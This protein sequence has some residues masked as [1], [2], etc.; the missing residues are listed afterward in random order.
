MRNECMGSVAALVAL[1]WIVGLPSNAWHAPQERTRVERQAPT[2]RTIAPFGRGPV[3]FE[4]N[5]GRTDPLVRYLQR[6]PRHLT[7]LTDSGF[8]TRAHESTTCDERGTVPS[9]ACGVTFVGAA[10]GPQWYA[11]GLLPGRTH[12]FV[13]PDA[14]R[15]VRNV[16]GYASV[17]AR[18]VWSGIDVEYHGRDGQLEYDFV[19]APGAD[20]THIAIDVHGADEL[21][22]SRDGD[23]VAQ[24]GDIQFVHGRPTVWQDH[25]DG[26]RPVP[27]RWSLAGENRARIQVAQF[28]ASLP[29]VIDPT[30]DVRFG[31][32]G[33]AEST[34]V[35]ADSSG[36]VA[37]VGHATGTGFPGIAPS[38]GDVSGT[39]DAF[40]VTFDV[41]GDLDDAFL[42]GSLGTDGFADVFFAPDGRAAAA[43]FTS[44]QATFPR[45]GVPDRGGL[46]S[47]D[48][49]VVLVDSSEGDPEFEAAVV[50]GA[51]QDAAT[52]MAIFADGLSG[53]GDYTLFVGIATRSNDLP[54]TPGVAHPDALGGGD[55]ALLG[56]DP[57][58]D[59]IA[60]GYVGGASDDIVGG[61]CRLDCLPDGRVGC[62]YPTF[63]SGLGSPGTIHEVKPGLVDSVIE[64]YSADLSTRI[65]GTYLK[66]VVVS[67]YAIA[68]DGT[69]V[70]SGTADTSSD[71]PQVTQNAPFLVPVDEPDGFLVVVE[72]DLSAEAVASWLPSQGFDQPV[73]AAVIPGAGADPDRFAVIGNCSAGFTPKGGGEGFHGGT[74][75]CYV[76]TMPRT[77]GSLSSAT[78]VGGSTR[79][80]CGATSGGTLGVGVGRP[81]VVLAD[82]T[83][84]AVC[85]TDATPADFP[86]IGDTRF[87]IPDSA[88][89][90][91][92]DDPVGG[93]AD[94][95][96]SVVAAQLRDAAKAG[97]DRASCRVSYV[98]SDPGREGTTAPGGDGSAGIVWT[99]PTRDGADLVVADAVID[100]A[101][102][103]WKARRKGRILAW[104]GRLENGEKARLTIDQGAREMT[105]NVT[106]IDFQA[107]PETSRATF[108]VELTAE[109]PAA[110][111][112]GT[113]Q[114]PTVEQKPGK[115]KATP[116]E[117]FP[118]GLSA[119]L[120]VTPEVLGPDDPYTA[121]VTLR[122][123]DP[124]PVQVTVRVQHP[125][126]TV[127]PEEVATVIE[128][129]V[130]VPGRAAGSAL[131]GLEELTAEFLPP[132]SPKN[133]RVELFVDGAGSQTVFI[134]VKP[135]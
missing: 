49:I 120:S 70:V 18:E 4:P 133:Q 128:A 113:A 131:A 6:A 79:D 74:S 109:S 87:G 36:R 76:V 71:D 48:S 58:L 29:L 96:C 121:R 126:L 47:V 14:S 88:V 42:F 46:G 95:E 102:P 57:S 20:P 27:G 19:V 28:D 108:Q 69:H 124:D 83:M 80:Q 82:G 12:H 51:L 63:S 31:A 40:L 122:N 134:K 22:I 127:F 24:A 64:I 125:V 8:T 110:P 132:N 104:S 39:Q 119:V 115:F 129:I 16:E 30:L 10:P 78:H 67:A 52:S 97:K 118:G 59:L 92:T 73:G 101:D 15:W 85:N 107:R 50:G 7:F 89:V 44:D 98:F 72:P 32:S 130:T 2:I 26:R 111:A 9:R 55:N 135:R 41:D 60:C 11:K 112:Q 35:A 21:R 5:R 56:F 77:G 1:V 45:T 53:S 62:A 17:A 93:A 100:L 38:P 94:L 103:A 66:A 34:A 68:D 33:G 114:S 25:P 116:G 86:E 61:G 23:L 105:L 117:D 54:T 75:D 3:R 99:M 90:C 81:L 65:V 13:G 43:G 106:G 91:L 123:G 84:I 37:V